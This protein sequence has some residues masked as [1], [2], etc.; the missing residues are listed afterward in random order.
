MKTR[1]GFVSNSSSSSFVVSIP[2]TVSAN[3]PVPVP[4]HFTFDLSRYARRVLTTQDELDRFVI[5]DCWGDK[6]SWG[7]YELGVY[8][9]A[10][11]AIA[12]GRYVMFG[13]FSDQSGDPIEH[14]LCEQGLETIIPKDSNVEVIDN[15][16]GY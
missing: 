12:A 8:R 11:S 6:S 14:M 13:R 2:A 7:D 1:N 9:Q 16:P 5:D 10:S 15:E 4:I 3:K